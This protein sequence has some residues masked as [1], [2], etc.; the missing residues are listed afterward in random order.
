MLYTKSI[1]HEKEETDGTRISIMSR[2]TLNDGITPDP[3]ITPT[4]FDEWMPELAPPAKLVGDYYHRNLPWEDFEQ[5]YLEHLHQPD[6]SPLVS[7][8]ATCA[9]SHDITLL[10]VEETAQYCHR[11][12][13]AEE[14]QRYE[15][16]LIV[17]H[18]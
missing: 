7:T 9:L 10:C 13:L 4:A 12:V 3:R 17:G 14:C 5:R 1:F 8:L 18:R 16:D 6:V 2:H 11:R 15:P